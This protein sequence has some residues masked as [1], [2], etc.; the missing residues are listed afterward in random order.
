M[1]KTALKALFGCLVLMAAYA[2]IKADPS[3]IRHELPQ[4]VIAANEGE[5][6]SS[7]PELISEAPEE[8]AESNAARVNMEVPDEALSM[9]E[10][11]KI[12]QDL[13]PKNGQLKFS[14]SAEA[15]HLHPALLRAGL[16]LGHL[17]EVWLKDPSE[18]K[19]AFDFYEDCTFDDRLFESVRALCYVNAIEVSVY[20]KKTDQVLAW[21]VN[22]S[23]Q[24]LASRLMA[25]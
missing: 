3:S 14:G 1:D 25:N 2:V 9:V 5:A 15:H 11:I 16:E 24:N 21:T 7:E 19:L 10:R 22:N 18:R 20:L 17:K 4:A 13:L 6:V 8:L 23:V 12:V